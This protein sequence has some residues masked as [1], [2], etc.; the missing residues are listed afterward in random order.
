MATLHPPPTPIPPRLPPAFLLTSPAPT[1]LAQ[2][3]EALVYRTTYLLPSIPSALK[4]RPPKRYRHPTLDARLTRHRILA[5]ARVL[6]RCRRAGVAVP[7]VYAADWDQGWLLME[8]VEGWTVRWV[9]DRW[10]KSREG[11]EGE[12]EETGPGEHGRGRE[13]LLR[14]LMARVGELVGRLHEIGIVHG[15]LTTSNLMLRPP[16]PPLPTSSSTTP[17]SSTPSPH[18][19]FLASRPPSTTAPSPPPHTLASLTGPITLI[20]FG[21]ASQS[22]Q[23]EDKAV[24][25]YVLERAFGSTHPAAEKL[26]QEAVLGAYGASYKGA[27]VALKRLDEVRMRGRKKNMIG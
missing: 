24:D 20:D 12:L 13:E 4:Y 5:E 10:L 7:A 21:L 19:H 14:D 18:P 15:D 22:L 8:W 11:D 26:F 9:L 2:G 23:D 6:A 17:S 3:A 16:P 25:L 27:Q 1:L